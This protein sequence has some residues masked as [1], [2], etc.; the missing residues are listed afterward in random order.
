MTKIEYTEDDIPPKL[1]Q[2]ALDV[3]SASN[4]GGVVHSMSRAVAELQ[5]NGKGTE[6]VNQH[7]VVHLFA[8][9]LVWL[10]CGATIDASSDVYSR[11]NMLCCL[12]IAKAK[13]IPVAQ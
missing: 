12:A 13:S 9:Q 1:A 11:D 8:V 2:Q 3:Q 7:P 6:W 10:N 4:L 5:K